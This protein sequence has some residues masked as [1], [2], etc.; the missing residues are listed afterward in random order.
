MP[1]TTSRLHALPSPSRTDDY[2]PS[3]TTVWRAPAS[4]R[5]I[6]T[7]VRAEVESTI[8][9]IERDHGRWAWTGELTVPDSGLCHHPIVETFDG[10]RLEYFCTQPAGHTTDHDGPSLVDPEP[11]PE[12][13]LAHGCLDAPTES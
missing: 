11:E 7:E 10:L 12:V 8:R 5:D 2:R 9:R 6:A 4:R 13:D 1:E 3:S